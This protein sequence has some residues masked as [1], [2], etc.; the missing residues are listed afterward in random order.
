MLRSRAC[1]TPA[2][3]LT[4]CTCRSGV[5]FV[6][7]YVDPRELRGRWGI[8]PDADDLPE[9]VSRLL[10]QHGT[11]RITA[12][13]SV[14]PATAKRWAKGGTAPSRVNISRLQFVEMTTR[15]I[16]YRYSERVAA[17]WLTQ[18]NP[19]LGYQAPVR[20]LAS[21]D[22]GSSEWDA[23]AKAATHF[24]FGETRDCARTREAALAPCAPAPLVPGEEKGGSDAG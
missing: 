14:R 5:P 8:T 9:L 3:L 6:A 10:A 4:S 24:T 20:V 21:S 15:M 11:W 17:T 2:V 7:R 13:C 18:A 23:V 12:L 16:S 19:W 22:P 1:L